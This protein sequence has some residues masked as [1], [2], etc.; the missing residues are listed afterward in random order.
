MTNLINQNSKP[1]SPVAIA[2][3]LSLLLSLVILTGCSNDDSTG[4]GTPD[5]TTTTTWDGVG[6]FWVTTLDATSYDQYTYYSFEDRDVVPLTDAQAATSMDWDI[7]FK[8]AFIKSNGGVSGPGGATSVDLVESGIVAANKF[9]EVTADDVDQLTS[10]QWMEDSYDLALDSLW[11]YNPITHQL[12]PKQYVY[13]LSDAEGHFVKFQLLGSF[14]DQQPPAQGKMILKY[15]YQ[16]T[17]NDSSLVGT[18]EIDTVDAPNGFY[19]DFSSGQQVT[20]VDPQNSTAWDIYVEAYDIFLNSTVSG[21][22]NV[23]AFAAYDGLSNKTDFDG[24]TAVNQFGDF[25]WV[26]DELASAFTATDWYNYNFQ[27]H[28][29]TSKRHTYVVKSGGKNYKVEIVSFYGES[30]SDDAV[31][32]IHWS[33]L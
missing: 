20:P 31:Y 16:P 11:I 28:T 9:T 8:R 23:A 30:S 25:R 5:N 29:L 14:D 24:L 10:D 21:S 7:A 15:F 13:V 12:L 1:N 32:T 6:Q 33:E 2:I 22:G 19:Y 4:P 3:L 18:A 17:L 26:Q 27:T